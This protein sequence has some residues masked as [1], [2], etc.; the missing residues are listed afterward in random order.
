M[1]LKLEGKLVVVTGAARGIGAETAKVFVQEGAR[2]LLVDLNQEVEK[3]AFELGGDSL[4]CDL[5]DKKADIKVSTTAAKLGGVSVLV[6]NA[7]ISKPLPFPEITDENWSEVMDVN[8]GIAFRL[9]RAMWP[10]LSKNKGSVVN[11]ASFASKR[12]TLFGNNSSYVAAKHAISGLTRATAFEGAK[13]G[14]RVNAVAPGTVD[15]ELIRSVHKPDARKKILKFIPQNRFADT[16]EI[17]DVIAFLASPRASHICGEI[18]NV[19]GG[20]LMD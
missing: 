2:V 19:N 14:I 5:T 12:S 16:S 13:Q 6:N 4:V 17:A 18:V 20:M 11:L 7:G 10:Q 15:T 1:D 3:L 9:T 8:L